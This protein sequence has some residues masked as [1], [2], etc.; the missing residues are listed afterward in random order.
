MLEALFGGGRVVVIFGGTVRVL[1]WNS[2][3]VR[4]PVASKKQMALIV[5]A[6]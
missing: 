5:C 6:P 1:R 2:V 3:C 4:V